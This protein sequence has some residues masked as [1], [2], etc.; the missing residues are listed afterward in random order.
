[1]GIIDV[2][3]KPKKKEHRVLGKSIQDSIPYTM[4][5]RDGT[6]ETEPGTYTRAF[7][8]EDI[9]FKI[10]SLQEQ[11]DIFHAYESL[12]NSFPTGVKFQIVILNRAADSRTGLISIVRR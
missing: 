9:N 10:A 1:M 7:V 6:I 3:K 5:F 8:L 4:V 12:L 2:F 11:T